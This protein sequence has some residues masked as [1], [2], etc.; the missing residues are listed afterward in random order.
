VAGEERVNLLL[1]SLPENVRRDLTAGGQVVD[2]DRSDQ[3]FAI[4]GPVDRL[5]FPLSGM[6]SLTVDTSEGQTVE[7]AIAG[8]EG[9]AGAGRYLGR[10]LAET[11][12]IVQVPG[13]MLHISAERV[14]AVAARELSLRAAMDSY[15]QSMMVELSQ[16]AVCNQVHS[17][18]QRTSRWLL[19]ASD[20]AGTP[21][22]RLTHEFLSQ[23]LGIRRA[24]VT[25]VVGIF[26]RAGLTA[27]S[28]GL[29]TVAD[30][31][32]LIEL[33]CECYGIVREATPTYN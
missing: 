5:S 4:G 8:R 24:T 1:A 3:L 26:T 23:M 19:H 9:F 12:G 11:N 29:I 27:A 15:L 22:L 17:V 13:Q 14:R 25:N 2:H 30:R 32:A 21:E 28:R 7:V 6:I 20:R 16:S 10:Q 33:A 18:E 31:E